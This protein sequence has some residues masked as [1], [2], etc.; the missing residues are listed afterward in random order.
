MSEQA[1]ICAE[2]KSQGELV[3]GK[4]I[5][6]H[7]PDLFKLHFWL[8][9]PCFAYVGCHPSGRGYG[10]GTRPLGTMA[11]ALTRQARKQAHEMF[12]PIWRKGNLTRK[13][14]YTLLAKHLQIPVDACHIGSFDVSTCNE[15]IRWAKHLRGIL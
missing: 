10:D 4:E 6:P 14:V 1:P 13:Q 3:S 2:C 9:R 11:N 5:Y 8:C 7:R 12:D 15:V